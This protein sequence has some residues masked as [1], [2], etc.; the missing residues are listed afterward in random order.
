MKKLAFLLIALVIVIV[1][2]NFIP[3][4]PSGNKE[5]R[6]NGN[7]FDSVNIK[8]TNADIEI[9]STNSNQATVEL[10]NNRNR[11]YELKADVKGDTLEIEVKRR[12][13]HW[14]T[15]N[16]FDSAPDLKVYLPEK[17]YDLVKAKTD[18]GTVTIENLNAY[19]ANAESANGKI[20]L[21]EITAKT[22][23]ALTRNG[24]IE[25]EEL[26]GEIVAKSS[27]GAIELETKSLDHPIEMKTNNGNIKIKS[28]TQ[29]KNVTFELDTRNGNIRV[30]GDKHFDT[31]VGNGKNM[32]KLTTHNGN[33]TIE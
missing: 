32:V 5:V 3:I 22:I 6:I 7:R 17:T 4:G 13:I 21:D 29:P 2:I 27:N 26:D 28:A 20:V 19:E 1:A 24:K 25:M 14:F 18:N 11:R 10:D 33:I 9:E 31:V 8:T 23:S 16:F 30:F 15:F 12:W